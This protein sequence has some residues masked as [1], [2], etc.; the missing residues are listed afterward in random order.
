MRKEKNLDSKP[1]QLQESKGKR[2][3]KIVAALLIAS[4]ASSLCPG[5]VGISEVKG[6]GW[7]VLP[8]NSPEIIAIEVP[9]IAGVE[10]E[11]SQKFREFK[12]LAELTEW[13][14][15]NGLHIRIIA[16]KDGTIDL[17][18][19]KSTSQYD[20]DDYAEALQRK[21]LE[22]GFLMSQQLVLNGRVYGRKVS[23]YTEPHMGNLTVI[24]NSIY[25]IESVPP[26]NI[27]RITSRD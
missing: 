1:R 3:K 26:H 18:H 12:D 27:V 4:L 8:T 11:V 14:E 7:D 17:L 22:Q 24:G 2:S 13:L 19:H 23:E 15:N 20:C 21:A 25:Y 9:V 16:D 10:K 5:L 6:A